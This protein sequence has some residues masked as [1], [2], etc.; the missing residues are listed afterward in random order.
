MVDEVSLPPTTPA[1]SEMALQFAMAG[2]KVDS[3]NLSRASSSNALGMTSTKKRRE[4]NQERMDRKQAE[5]EAK[6]QEQIQKNDGLG[7]EKDPNMTPNMVAFVQYVDGEDFRQKGIR[8]ARKADRLRAAQNHIRELTGDEELNLFK[9]EKYRHLVGM[10]TPAGGGNS[11]DFRDQ[12]RYSK[13]FGSDSYR[14][15][16]SFG[17]DFVPGIDEEQYATTEAYD[18]FGTAP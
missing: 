4:T 10:V 11:A 3:G 7:R 15:G 1:D 14:R 5:K 13:V 18:G 16:G 2:F 17:P 6:D 9:D 12:Q 8:D